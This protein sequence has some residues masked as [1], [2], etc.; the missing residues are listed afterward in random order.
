MRHF[1]NTISIHVI[2]SWSYASTSSWSSIDLCWANK[3]QREEQVAQPGLLLVLDWEGHRHCSDAAGSPCS[4][5]RRTQRNKINRLGR[6]QKLANLAWELQT[7][8]L[9]RD[10]STRCSSEHAQCRSTGAGSAAASTHQ[11]DPAR[12]QTE[13]EEQKNE[14]TRN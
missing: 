8:E 4:R 5:T 11:T 10:L 7:L 9:T 2:C 12:T 6:T 1:L 14:R 13:N 3:E